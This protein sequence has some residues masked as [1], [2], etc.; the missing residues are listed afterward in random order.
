M[1]PCPVHPLH[2]CPSRLPLSN[3]QYQWHL[4]LYSV[5]IIFRGPCVR[6]LRGDLLGVGQAGQLSPAG[7]GRWGRPQDWSRSWMQ[8]QMLDTA[9]NGYWLWE[10]CHVPSH[11]LLLHVIRGDL[12]QIQGGGAVPTHQGE[13]AEHAWLEAGHWLWELYFRGETEVVFFDRFD[14]QYFFQGSV[15]VGL[16]HPFQDWVICGA[17]LHHHGSRAWGPVVYDPG[18][19]LKKT[20]LFRKSK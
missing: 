18:V 13:E 12:H 14:W 7:P 8:G 9:G 4:L 2:P 20:C 10:F 3:Q 16:P 19:N 6:I 5:Q 11:V 17:D 15:D 1:A